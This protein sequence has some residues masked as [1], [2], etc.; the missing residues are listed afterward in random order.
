MIN[1]DR[2]TF[3]EIENYLGN[4]TR[5]DSKHAYF[6]CPDCRDSGKD[7]LIYTFSNG[8]LKSFCCDSCRKVCSEIMKQRKQPHAGQKQKQ[9]QQLP[10]EAKPYEF[11]YSL[12]AQG[13]PIIP[14]SYEKW[15]LYQDNCNQALIKNTKA[16]DFLLKKRGISLETIINCGI[17]IDAKKHYWVIP[18]YNYHADI[19]KQRLVGFEYRKSDFTSFGNNKCIKEQGTPSCIAQINSKL[20]T[21][22]ILIILEGFF[23]GYIFWQHLKEQGQSKFYH[24]LT[25]SCGVTGIINHLKNFDFSSYKKVIL[26]LD[27]DDKGV[28]AMNEAK[29]IYPFIETIIMNCGCKD[30]NEHYMGCLNEQSAKTA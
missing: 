6:Q 16:L 25:P 21:A 5:R 13:F 1:T 26:Y 20:P 17:G 19:F 22:E 9:V 28:N 12:D 7:N 24:I 18:I 15:L 2:L 30:F 3:N 23:D 27:S 11:K 4:P 10:T 14:E 29:N 8:L